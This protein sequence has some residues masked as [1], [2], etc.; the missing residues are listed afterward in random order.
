[1][2]GF[3]FASIAFAIAFSTAAF[4]AAPNYKI[5]DRI[6]VPDGGFDYATFDSSTGRVYMPRTDFTTVVDT[7][8]GKA[9]Q[10]D[11]A[12]HGQILVPVPGTTLGVV[13]QR[14]DGTVLIVDTRT[15]KAVATI[16]AG[17]DPD[18]AVYDPYSKLVFVMKHDG[19][20]AT[21]IDPVAG[22]SVA[23]IPVGGRLEFPVSDGAGK[24]FVNETSG[25]D[26]AVIDVNSRTVTA[27]Y[28]LDGCRIGVTGLA[29]DPKG[30]L[31]IA[32]CRSGVAKVLEAGTGKEVASLPIADGPDAVIYDPVRQLAF[33]P[34]GGGGGEG[35]PE[36]RVGILEV[37]A[38][39]D[40]KHISVVQH[41][42]TQKGTRTGTLDPN[43][44]RLYLMGFQPDPNAPPVPEGRGVPR[45]PGTYE[46]LVV[47]P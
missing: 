46:V 13:T 6:R 4:A 18:G 2:N 14:V 39:S 1:M 10:L 30:R 20:D 17:M 15:D 16:P 32:S 3:R 35:P 45:P 12:R 24:V 11:S 31:L 44:G 19:R 27:H 26:I 29:Y 42:P 22:K 23:T 37:I 38:L 9:S 33:I 25:P 34:C 8:T 7:K 43:T 41:V 36:A 28:K 5:V 40:P 47:A 21:I